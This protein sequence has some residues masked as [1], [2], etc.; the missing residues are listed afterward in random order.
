MF[1]TIGV[2]FISVKRYICREKDRIVKDREKERES[3]ISRIKDQL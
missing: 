1:G 2:V 3:I